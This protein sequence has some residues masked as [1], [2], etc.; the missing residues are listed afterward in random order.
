M[1]LVLYYIFLNLILDFINPAIYTLFIVRSNRMLVFSLNYIVME[2]NTVAKAAVAQNAVPAVSNVE[3]TVS[4]VELLDAKFG[5]IVKLSFIEFIEDFGKDKDGNR[6]KG[7]TQNLLFN[8]AYF[9]GRILSLLPD[10]SEFYGQ[11]KKQDDSDPI[12]D[13]I[14]RFLQGGKIQLERSY[15]A[16]GEIETLADGSEV[17]HKLD[18]YT[19]EIVGAA[20]GVVGTAV[21][22]QL[23]KKREEKLLADMMAMMGL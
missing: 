6:V 3:V 13:V 1:I 9:V 23:N 11:S 20:Y 10:L 19:N 16:A 8:R 17:T 12:K 18:K 15:H 4:G 5:D 14:S 22:V 21:I 2:N 7:K